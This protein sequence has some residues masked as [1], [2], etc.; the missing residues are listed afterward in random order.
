MTLREKL[1]I[2]WIQ[3]TIR[4]FSKEHVIPFK[5]SIKNASRILILFPDGL[6]ATEEKQDQKLFEES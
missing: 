4:P 2:K 5:E 3:Y 1:E 6:L